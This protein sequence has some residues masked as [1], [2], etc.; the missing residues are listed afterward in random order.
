MYTYMCV[1]KH[2]HNAHTNM[3]Y[4]TFV[5]PFQPSPLKQKYLL[6]LGFTYMFTNRDL[7]CSPSWPETLIDQARWELRDPFA[8]PPNYGDERHRSSHPGFCKTTN[9]R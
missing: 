3:C 6:D 4:T 9:L 8:S 1:N 5:L 7:L 2:T